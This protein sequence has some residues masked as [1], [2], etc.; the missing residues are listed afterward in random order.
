MSLAGAL[1]DDPD[2]KL[3]VVTNGRS[4]LD[5]LTRAP[6]AYD[7]VILGHGLSEIIALECIAFIQ[8]LFRRLPILI[9]THTTEAERLSELA[10][11]GIRRAHILK[12][13]TDPKTFAA[14]V[15]NAL[16]EETRKR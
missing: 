13:P 2:L 6:K 4:A 7:L 11:L 16:S 15:Q 5:H 14:W 8:K 1:F 10:A 12:K 3:D 9:L